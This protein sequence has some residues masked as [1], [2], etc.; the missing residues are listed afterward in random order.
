MKPGMVFV[1]AEN[2]SGQ[3]VIGDA[4]DLDEQSFRAFV[5][6]SLW[7]AGVVAAMNPDEVN[8]PDIPLR[9]KPGVPGIVPPEDEQ[10]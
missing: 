7:N 3:P 10:G 9:L 8:G 6:Q 4:L 2:D 5:L 1:R